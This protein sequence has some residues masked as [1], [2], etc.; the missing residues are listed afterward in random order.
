MHLLVIL[1][2]A[3]ALAAD[4]SVPE[5]IHLV[6]AGEFRG[7]DGRGPYRLRDAAALITASMGPGRRL[8]LDENHSTD[9]AATRGEPAPA[10]GWIVDLQS[11]P[12]GIWGASSGRS[13]VAISSPTASTGASVPSFCALEMGRR[14]CSCCVPP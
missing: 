11:R 12:D 4:G 8:P 7:A 2:S 10:R 5:W 1:H 9:L 3:L 14:C 6:P 13:P